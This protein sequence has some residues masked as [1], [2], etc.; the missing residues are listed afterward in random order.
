M[1]NLNTVLPNGTFGVA[2]GT[3]NANFSLIVN[4]INSLEY[5]ST[6]SKGIHN[7]G[8]VPSTT[9]IPNAVS[10]DW[11]MVLREG[12]TFPADI[13]TYNGTSWTKG[14]AWSPEDIDLSD[15]ASK[16]EMATAITDSLAKAT[17]RMGYGVATAS[18]NDYSVTIVNFTL[19][20]NGGSIRVKMPTAATGAA[21]LDITDTGAKT[22]WYNGA[23]VSSQNT[24]EA[25][26]T[27]SVFYDG[28]K[29]MASNSQGGGGYAEKIKYNNSQSGLASNN[30]QGALDEVDATIDKLY[31]P[32]SEQIT[33]VTNTITWT[34]GYNIWAEPNTETPIGALH[35]TTR[36]M[37]ASNFIDVSQYDK[38]TLTMLT[39]IGGVSVGMAFYAS[40]NESSV[41]SAERVSGEGT[42]IPFTYVLKTYNIPEGANYIRCTQIESGDDFSLSVIKILDEATGLVPENQQDIAEINEKI[43]NTEFEIAE[44]VEDDLTGNI[45]WISGYNIW[46][47]DNGQNPIG[48]H[49]TTAPQSATNYVSISNYNKVELTMPTNAG[50][51]AVGIAFYAD[52]NESSVISSEY[53]E[54]EGISDWHYTARTYDIPE[55]ANYIRCTKLNNLSGFYLKGIDTSGMA[56]IKGYKAAIDYLIGEQSKQSVLNI[57]S[58][59]VKGDGVTDDTAAIQEALD[60]GGAIYFPAGTY[61]VNST[62]VIKDGTYIQGDGF[63]K[64]V[65][66]A[67]NGANLV[68]VAW[69]GTVGATTSHS[70]LYPIVRT[71]SNS[72]GISISGIGVYDDGA[73]TSGNGKT[74]VGILPYYTYGMSIID[75]GA[76]HINWLDP[77]SGTMDYYA[78]CAGFG[79]YVFNAS[80]IRICGGHYEYGGYESCGVENSHDVY[81]NECFIG[82]GWRCAFQVHKDAYNVH[83]DH[84][85]VVQNIPLTNNTFTSAAVILDGRS[86]DGLKDV[87]ICDNWIYSRTP[88]NDRI[89]G[90]IKCVLANEANITITGNRID[91]NNY[92]VADQNDSQTMVYHPYNWIITDN[93]I[94]STNKAISLARIINV[95]VTGNIIDCPNE[96]VKVKTGSVVGNNIFLNDST[97]TYIN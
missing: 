11:C 57:K 87:F 69:R 78:E 44:I 76:S 77:A 36:G 84:C 65:I 42:G 50:D 6:K 81:F 13:W 5:A 35:A 38:I 4:A 67:A 37:R 74:R 54:H 30:V 15:Y 80:N 8:F 96:A 39:S 40:A 3:I 89:E 90:G 22:I 29:Y 82:S 21:T 86:T 71:E 25:G 56:T 70:T 33:N 31:K 83:L 95:I 49:Q 45:T 94:V 93:N 48:L 10:G 51:V 85:T 55:G 60:N 41:V 64:T 26:E 73:Y 52:N 75:C 79:L 68:G 34:A 97:V 1:N 92:A 88:E 27:I 61:L 58:Y 72:K 16:T 12:N 2:V 19:P 46:A 17:A 24:W 18:G 32:S 43:N 59:G 66:K 63:D 20:T 53:V 28:T 91:V 23:A 62:L 14:G 7:Y 47:K 9:T